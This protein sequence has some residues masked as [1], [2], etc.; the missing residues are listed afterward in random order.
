MTQPSFTGTWKFNPAKSALQIPAPDSSM[1]VIEHSEPRFRL[2]RTHVFGG[3]SDTFNI[4]LTTDG[5]AVAV[6]HA[7][8]E[9]D[10][11]LR[12]EGDTL[13]FDSRLKREGEQATNV[14]RYSLS[15][16]GQTFT[17]EEQLRSR[18]HSHDNKWVFDKQ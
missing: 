11:S 14:V 4:N 9:I 8:F 10:G 2:E 6:F 16:D 13:V 3:K 5:K 17:A 15:A 18:D 1:F 7:G 12:W